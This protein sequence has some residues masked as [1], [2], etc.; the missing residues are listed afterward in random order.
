M[1]KR[2]K[3]IS[4]QPDQLLLYHYAELDANRRLKIEQHLQQCSGCRAELAALQSLLRAAPSPVA[5]LSP[6][7][8]QHFSSRVM[9][10][11]QPKRRRLTRPAL[12]LT[13]AGAAVVLISLNLGREITPTSPLSSKAPLKMAVDQGRLP[14]LELLQNL[15]LLDNFELVQQLDRLR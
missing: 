11:L 5:E 15:E 13:L 3:P 10:R 14:N 6:A 2:D 1:T 4:C 7:D 12:G 9:E 8:L